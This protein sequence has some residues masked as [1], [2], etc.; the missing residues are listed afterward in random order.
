MMITAK[1]VI[2]RQGN[3]TKDLHLY[4]I[5]S[6]FRATVVWAVISVGSRLKAP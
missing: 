5:L 2:N 3:D 6:K 4:D 1:V